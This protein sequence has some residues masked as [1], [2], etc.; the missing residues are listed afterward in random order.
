MAF[1]TP[2]LTTCI[3]V[4]LGH[5]ESNTNFSP[6]L[7]CD[8]IPYFTTCYQHNCSKVILHSQG[9]VNFIYIN[10]DFIIYIVKR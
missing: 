10:I 7:F 2:F 5:R 9:Y 3:G 6:I 4:A 1:G 8:T